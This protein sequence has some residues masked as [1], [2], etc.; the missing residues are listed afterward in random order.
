MMQV[1]IDIKSRIV[2]LKGAKLQCALYPR[3]HSLCPIGISV[4]T[5]STV[6]IFVNVTRIL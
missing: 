4:K 6:K 1:I 5:A 2:A 3:R